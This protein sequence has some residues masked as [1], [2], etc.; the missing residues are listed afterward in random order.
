[1]V[2]ILHLSIGV[3]CNMNNLLKKIIPVSDFSK[4]VLT[5]TT[6]AAV[7]QIIPIALSPILSRLYSP[8]EF[9]VFSIFIAIASILG[10]IATLRY[11]MA[12][13]LPDNNKDAFNVVAVSIILSFI[14]SLIVFVGIFF[15]N[16]EILNFTHQKGVYEYV[17]FIP[18]CI[19]SIGIYQ[20]FNYWSTRLQS[21]KN[22]AFSRIAQT[23]FTGIINIIYGVLQKGTLGLVLGNI[24]GQII[25]ALVL[26][27]KAMSQS[28]T[29]LKFISQKKIKYTIARYKAHATINTLH[30][31]L[32]NILSYG[33]SFLLVFF[34][35]DAIVGFY[36]FS[37]RILKAPLSIIG[38]AM[39]QVFF[40]QANE[41][42]NSNQSIRNLILSIYKKQFLI[43]IIPFLILFVFA[44][45]L[46][47]F[48]FGKQ[49]T[50]AGEVTQI[51]APWIFLNFLVSPV[52]SLPVIVNKQKQGFLITLADILLKTAAIAIGGYYHNYVIAFLLLSSSGCLL[53]IFDLFWYYHIAKPINIIERR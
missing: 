37:F 26:A 16:D 1:L 4:N 12:I 20:T 46:F 24:G 49:W 35:T 39:S 5:L 42:Y 33:I 11:E 52:S 25:A 2:L 36:S 10:S 48:I 7:A 38:T 32:D 13:M 53:I 31:L 22:N 9:G 40:Q 17:Y 51:L 14:I 3:Y 43:G 50:E 44:P 15:L 18:L 45:V 41:L 27:F 29:Y 23:S 19:F 28:K 6:G 30:V 34:F 8:Q 21:Y 47:S